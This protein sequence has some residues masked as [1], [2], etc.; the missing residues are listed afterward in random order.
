M[1]NSTLKKAMRARRGAK[2][3]A[4]AIALA[5]MFAAG[6]GPAW[7]APSS[8]GSESYGVFADHI[9]AGR[10]AALTGVNAPQGNAYDAGLKAY[11]AE[12]NERDHGVNG[13]RL[14]FVTRD[15]GY[16]AERTKEVS[17]KLIAEDHVFAFVGIQGTSGLK[18]LLGMRE[19]AGIAK[20]GSS[21]GSEIKDPSYFPTRNT[22]Y[23]DAKGITSHLN[24]L[25]DRT[26]A[27]VAQDDAFGKDA[28]QA[29]QRAA[30]E[31]NVEITSIVMMKSN[32]D[33][34]GAAAALDELMKKAGSR[35]HN[36][37]A[38]LIDTPSGNFIK[39][40]RAA[41]L[42]PNLFAISSSGEIEATAG[43]AAVENVIVSQTAPP[44]GMSMVLPN[45]PPVPDDTTPAVIEFH[46]LMAKRAPQY[47]NSVVAFE[48][49]M[50]ARVYVE[51]LKG[52]GVNPTRE[53]FAK[54]LETFHMRNI[55][56]FY[57]SYD[58]P[59]HEGNH[60]NELVMWRKNG[61]QVF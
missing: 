40:F 4:I 18:A 8:S 48:G 39:A 49:Y 5:A 57:Y 24:N 23:D 47:T 53:S 52:A 9:V 43:L 55:G 35:T 17:A 51:G 26:I 15:D 29:M 50:A 3:G 42:T 37:A 45:Y 20:V 34:A 58:T 56:G 44:M 27:I 30:K 16:V 13:R 19:A 2:A 12:V 11:L 61:G 1:F 22:N 38:L 54:S 28:L 46:K 41:K 59:A 6:S 60:F 7:S 25:N 21:S 10:P 14:D 32:A 33:L 36:V 31:D